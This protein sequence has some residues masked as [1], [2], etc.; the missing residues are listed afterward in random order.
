M[1]D[2]QKQ[3]VPAH[4]Q[5]QVPGSQAVIEKLPFQGGGKLPPASPSGHR[6]RW[7]CA[8]PGSS[9]H[10]GTATPGTLQ[11]V[12]QGRY[13]FTSTPSVQ[14]M[15]DPST[16]RKPPL[17]QHPLPAVE[18]LGIPRQCT[19]RR[20]EEVGDHNTHRES[21]SDLPA[22][23]AHLVYNYSEHPAGLFFLGLLT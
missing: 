22:L 4:I 6:S 12:T 19:G 20:R 21:G 14:S 2:R 7:S 8:S 5:F 23:L 18:P 9:T 1:N 11:G 17:D 16:S 10:E 13:S 15:K 3:D